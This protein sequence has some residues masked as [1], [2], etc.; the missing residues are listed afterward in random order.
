[1][2]DETPADPAATDPFWAPVRRRHPDV[3]IVLLPA[4]QPAEPDP[5]LPDPEPEPE[6]AE[7]IDPD[8][9]ARDA[10]AALAALWAQAVGESDP[11]EQQSHWL[12]GER[13]GTLR[14]EATWTLEGTTPEQST[15]ALQRVAESLGADGWHVLTPPDGLPRVQAGRADGL[16][17]AEVLL[18]VVPASARLALRHRTGSHPAP[19]APEGDQR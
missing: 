1:M 15:A 4:E 17:R 19:P 18:L 8:E 2:P 3:D 16:D 11:T 7:P 6:P 10:E 9:L 14:H 12:S 13:P 5:A